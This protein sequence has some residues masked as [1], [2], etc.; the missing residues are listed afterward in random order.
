MGRIVALVRRLS[1]AGRLAGCSREGATCEVSDAILRAVE[2]VSGR[3]GD[4]RVDFC[5]AP[6]PSAAIA[7]PEQDVHHAV[8]ALLVNAVEAVPERRP[9]SVAVAVEVAGGKVAIRVE[10]DGVGL[11]DE[12]LR[13][14]FE[15][16]YSTKPPGRGPGL[17]LTLAQAFARRHGG[18]VRLERR[19]RGGTLAILT[20]PT[21]PPGSDRLRAA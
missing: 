17:G 4:G 15:P 6:L 11:C 2:D 21:A 16:F 1:E 13:R 9:G 7:A 14:A 19:S 18:E 12:A 20:L 10:D 3:C 8:L 5:L